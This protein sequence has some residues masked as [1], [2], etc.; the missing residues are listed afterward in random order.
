MATLNRVIILGRLGG[1]PE[2]RHTGSGTAV[3]SFR[4]A[5]SD[6]RGKDKDP[7]TTWH[8]VVVWGKTAENTAKYLGKGS[9]ALVEGRILQRE[10]ETKD[11]Q[12][13]KVTEIHAEHVVFVGKPREKPAQQPQGSGSHDFDLPF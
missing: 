4:M 11:G 7:V 3:A 6:S 2:L 8:D 5:T 1:D 12:K 13:R 9:E 10:Y